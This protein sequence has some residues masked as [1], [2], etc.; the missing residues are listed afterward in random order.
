MSTI[1]EIT[2]EMKLASP[3]LAAIPIG[4]RNHAL[5]LIKENILAH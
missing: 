3:I 2:A 1:H 4:T 5:D